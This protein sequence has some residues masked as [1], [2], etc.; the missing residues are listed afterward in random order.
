[1]AQSATDFERGAPSV[2]IGGEEPEGPRAVARSPRQLFWAKFKQDKLAMF[3][4]SL[5]LLMIAGALLSPVAATVTGHSYDEQFRSAQD[6]VS[7]LNDFGTPLGPNFSEKFYFGA[8]D[9]GRDLFVRVLRG[10]WVSLR[11]AILATGLEIAIG[12]LMGMLAGYLRGWVDTVLSRLMDL[13]LSIPFLLLGISLSVSLNLD[14]LGF[15]KNGEPLVLLIIVFFGWPYI[16]RI[17]RGQTL[18]IRESQFIEAAHS[19]GASSR[20][21]MLKE[22]L[23][24]LVAPIVVY[25]T[26]IIP[27]NI[28]AEASLSFLGVGIQEPTPAWGTMLARAKDFVIYGAAW[29]YMFFPGLALFLTVLGFNLLGDGLRDAADPKTAH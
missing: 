12:V 24:N 3:G 17:V 7:M 16:A 21:V 2:L 4:G 19:I 23:P 13:V 20:W 14:D 6:G 25:S 27:V 15:L 11:I 8:D 9:L 5:V 10:G 18:S 26:L 22:I 28:I 1:V 29:W